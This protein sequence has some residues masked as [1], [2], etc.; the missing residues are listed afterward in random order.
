MKWSGQ[1]DEKVSNDEFKCF[2]LWKSCFSLPNL[3]ICCV[4][5]HRRYSLEG[6][7]EACRSECKRHLRLSAFERLPIAE[8][9][10]WHNFFSFLWSSGCNW[11][12]VYLARRGCKWNSNWTILVLS[13]VSPCFQVPAECPK[14]RQRQKPIS[15]HYRLVFLLSKQPEGRLERT[16]LMCAG[17]IVMNQ[18]TT[19]NNQAHNVSRHWQTWVYCLLV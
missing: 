9:L 13:S 8:N 1:T 18:D 4:L 14:A 15:S 6:I 17:A 16:N 7:F 2:P 3:M 19:I 5:V 12:R 10:S 11:N